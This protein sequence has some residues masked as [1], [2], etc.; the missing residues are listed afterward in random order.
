MKRGQKSRNQKLVLAFVWIGIGEGEGCGITLGRRERDAG[1]YRGGGGA[2]V[3][4]Y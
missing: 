3:R 1:V 4:Y 2:A